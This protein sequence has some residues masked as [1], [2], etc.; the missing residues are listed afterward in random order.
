M[1][2]RRPYRDSEK[3]RVLPFDPQ[4][5]G[6]SHYGDSIREN[7]MRQTV[8]GSFDE[9]RSA[10]I[11]FLEEA[12][13]AGKLH[14]NLW[15][16]A[17]VK[18]TTGQAPKFPHAERLYFVQAIRYVSAAS[19]VSRINAGNA[20]IDLSDP[21]LKQFPQSG[22]VETSIERKKVLVTGCYDWLH[23][24]HV[25]F[26]EEVSEYGDVYAVVGHDAN[27]E[28]LKGKGHPQFP[29]DERRYGVG[30]LRYVK[31]ALVSTGH[32]WLDAAPE[33]EAIKPDIYAVNEDGDKPEKRELCEQR[34]MRYLVLKRLPK[35]GLTARSSTDLRGF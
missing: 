3:S 24:G 31:Q 12:A 26:F 32:G 8:T 22:P 34:G 25:R 17:L 30:A 13:K 15:S 1:G 6:S 23:S 19:I 5:P 4:P 21:K 11:R 28:L 29:E 7:I 16:D 27:I 20:Q 9:I 2:D 33:I 18:A 35:P 14:V 10:Q